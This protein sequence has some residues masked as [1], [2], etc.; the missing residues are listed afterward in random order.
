MFQSYGHPAWIAAFGLAVGL[1]GCGT[2]APKEKPKPTAPAESNAQEH[3]TGHADHEG[4]GDSSNNRQADAV[5]ADAAKGLAEL[6][7][8]DRT[9]AEKQLVCP[10]SGDVLGSVGKPYKVTIKDK[11]VFLCCPDCE[12]EITKNPDKYLAKLKADPPA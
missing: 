8:A 1:G 3:P 10:L 6:S 9:A 4:H 12:E 2:P 7:D 5:S 11:T